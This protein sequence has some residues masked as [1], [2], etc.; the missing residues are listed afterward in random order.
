MC[1]HPLAVD[2]PLPNLR[3]IERKKRLQKAGLAHWSTELKE[4]L[5]AFEA[6]VHSFRE[7]VRELV[8]YIL[9][10]AIHFWLWGNGGLHPACKRVTGS[11]AVVPSHKMREQSKISMKSTTE[12]CFPTD[13]YLV[14]L[15]LGVLAGHGESEPDK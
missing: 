13:E 1:S 12:C 15:F 14:I 3:D 8:C 10:P 11:G 2:Q 6:D 4:E 5:E 7:Q 9:S